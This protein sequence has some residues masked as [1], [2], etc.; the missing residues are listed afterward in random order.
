MT[1][2]RRDGQSLL[3]PVP[4]RSRA[5]ALLLLASSTSA[6]H[7]VPLPAEALIAPTGRR[8]M[9]NWEI[10]AAATGDVPLPLPSSPSNSLPPP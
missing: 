5:R 6:P 4:P 7:R 8:D 1:R 2:R 9:S 10:Y 3:A